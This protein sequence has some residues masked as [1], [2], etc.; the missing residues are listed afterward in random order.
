MA[1]C[2]KSHERYV[3]R[4]CLDLH[5]RGFSKDTGET[6]ERPSE[7]AFTVDPRQHVDP[8]RRNIR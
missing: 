6:R 5:Y 4:L 3:L 2:W 8:V 7:N 1:F